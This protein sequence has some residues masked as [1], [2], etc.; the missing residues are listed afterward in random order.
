M[1]GLTADQTNERLDM[2]FES[3]PDNRA[4]LMEYMKSFDYTGLVQI[5]HKLRG[6]AGS[7]MI[8]D[9][10]KAADILEKR[11]KAKDETAKETAAEL[12]VT[13]EMYLE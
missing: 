7:L 8:D 5:A 1:T 4:K 12:I 2:F 3:L 6:T 11:A 13:I 10:F 9:I